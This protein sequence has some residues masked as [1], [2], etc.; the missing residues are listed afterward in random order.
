[1]VLSTRCSRW[2]YET[3]SR[4]LDRGQPAPYPVFALVDG[5]AVASGLSILCR[6]GVPIV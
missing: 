5:S 6:R 3:E 4:A 1:M 2:S